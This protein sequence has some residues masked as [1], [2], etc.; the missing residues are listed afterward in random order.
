MRLVIISNRLPITVIKKENRFDYKES[1]GGL[2]TGLNAY[3]ESPE[4][5]AFDKNEFLWIGWPGISTEDKNKE[6]IKST[7]YSK[8]Q[9]YP[10]FL[11]RE[12]MN[13]FYYGFCNSTIWP[14]FHYFPLNVMYDE[15]YWAHYQYVNQIFCNAIEEI[16]K[17]DDMV[18]IHDYHLM[19][20]PSL[21]RAK[22]ENIPIGFFL[23]IPFP[24][25]EIFRILPVQ[26]RT[27][28]IKGLLGADLLGFH[29][30]DYTQYFLRCVLRISGYEHNLGQIT[31]ENRIVKADTFPMGIDY[32]KYHYMAKTF[33][34]KKQKKKFKNKFKKNKIILSLDRLDYTKGIFNRL[35]AYELFLEKNPDWREKVI[36]ILVVVPSRIAVERY[37]NMKEKIDEMVGRINGKFGH[38]DWTPVLYQYKTFSFEELA[39]LYNISDIALITPLRDGMNLIAKEYI[40]CK[41]DKTGV[42]ILSEMAGSAKEMG[43][44]IIINPNSNKEM[45]E[46]IK[47]ALDMQPEEQIKRNTVMQKRLQSYTVIKWADDFINKL[48]NIKQLQT[49]F[50][51][52]IFNQKFKN[53][54]IKNFEHSQ[55]RLIL[56]D[57]DGTLIPFFDSP[58]KAKPTEMILRIL[59]QFKNMTQTDIVLISG[60]DKK[61]L[62]DWF[63]ELNINIV[64]EHGV[65]IKE[66]NHEWQLIKPLVKEWMPKIMPLLQIYVDR[67]PGSFIEEKEY[68]IVW[69]YRK[70]DPELAS[71]RAKELMD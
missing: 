39:V 40:A 30:N 60:R 29:T 19:L 20:L 53:E 48:L 65:W 28:I 43:E 15:E 62:M 63:N 16:I 26:W 68:S 61:T 52:K 34:V 24:S 56:L 70:S 59:E 42:L 67:L 50:E 17:P 2:A 11:S 64:A 9:S 71:L 4:K 12:A 36:L 14:L 57:Y 37:Q 32:N 35:Q 66:I 49:T 27:E 18:W 41:Y 51:A 47:Q 3:I 54:L 31:L 8:Y 38:L 10:V 6:Q 25:Y 58:E 45:A 5:K 33:E 44:A 21:L 55:K 23:H 46:A 22:M 13:K 7:L 1:I 69:H